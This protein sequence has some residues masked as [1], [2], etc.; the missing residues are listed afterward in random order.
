MNK[1]KSKRVLKKRRMHN[2]KNITKK[3]RSYAH[4]HS[5]H[6][7]CSYCQKYGRRKCPVHGQHKH[8][9]LK[10]GGCNCNNILAGTSWNSVD[11]GNYYP[12]NNDYYD[13]LGLQT[14]MK[15]Q[16]DGFLNTQNGGY[17][18]TKKKRLGT[19]TYK[20]ATTT[21]T[22][23]I[24]RKRNNTTSAIISKSKKIKGGKGVNNLLISDAVQNL[25][26]SISYNVGSA[27]NTYQGFPPPVNPLPFRDQMTYTR[28][29]W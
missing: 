19:Q 17:T 27:Y 6:Q 9:H 23:P 1:T 18:Y 11:G 5:A 8:K 26:R 21:T 14:S 13:N 25:P 4:T 28:Q 3:I 10:G 22:T 2:K 24:G 15:S 16:Y 12:L 7:K 20:T 29:S